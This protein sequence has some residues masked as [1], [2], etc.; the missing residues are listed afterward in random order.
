[1]NVYEIQG[2]SLNMTY[3]IQKYVKQRLIQIFTKDETFEDIHVLN[4][5][6]DISEL[7]CI[8]VSLLSQ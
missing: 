1:M 8:T 6:I 3:F 2:A 4:Y 5:A 7:L